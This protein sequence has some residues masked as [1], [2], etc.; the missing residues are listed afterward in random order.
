M[1]YDKVGLVLKKLEQSFSM[2]SNIR[3]SDINQFIRDIN[4]SIGSAFK[5]YAEMDRLNIKIKKDEVSIL[6][7][8]FHN[9]THSWL[10]TIQLIV[11]NM[12]EFFSLQDIYFFTQD[13]SEAYPENKHI[14]DKIRQIL[15]KLR[16][17]GEIVFSSDGNYHVVRKTNNMISIREYYKEL[18]DDQKDVLDWFYDKSYTVDMLPKDMKTDRGNFLVS[19]AMGI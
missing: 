16:D 10:E 12:P 18:D 6:G 7:I 15:Q 11:N 1:E 19:P 17:D 9:Y 4:F 8:Y 2:H 5:I 14:K 3:Q 13:L